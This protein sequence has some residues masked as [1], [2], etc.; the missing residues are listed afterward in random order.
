MKNNKILNKT[1][2][3]VLITFAFTACGDTTENKKTVAPAPSPTP[4]NTSALDTKLIED[5]HIPAGETL[6]LVD[7]K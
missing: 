4:V 3:T 6:T 1:I 5:C 2:I 7:R